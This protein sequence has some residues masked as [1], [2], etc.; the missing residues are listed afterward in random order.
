MDN[1]KRSTA[2]RPIRTRCESKGQKKKASYGGYI[3]RPIGAGA[4]TARTGR[5]TERTIACAHESNIPLASSKTFGDIARSGTGVLP[6][7]RPISSPCSTWPTSIWSGGNLR[8]HREQSVQTKR[9]RSQ[10]PV[11]DPSWGRK[12]PH[13]YPKRHHF[14]H[15]RPL[16]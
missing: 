8:S 12:H 1:K 3:A 9:N 10:W 13:K 6:R 15:D 4:S 16:N 14:Q 2:T 7:K 5:S 11:R